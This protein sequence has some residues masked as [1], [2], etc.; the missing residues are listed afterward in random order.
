M[1]AIKFTFNPWVVRWW[2]VRDWLGGVW[3]RVTDHHWTGEHW[4]NHTDYGDEHDGR[5]YCDRCGIDSCE[6]E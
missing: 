2:R 5:T 3:C 6:Y 4:I 1:K